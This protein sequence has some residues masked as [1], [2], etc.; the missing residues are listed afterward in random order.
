MQFAVG[1]SDG[2]TTRQFFRWYSYGITRF[3]VSS[4][5]GAARPPAAPPVSPASRE[6][7][8]P[9]GLT[10]GTTMT[11]VFFRSFLIFFLPSL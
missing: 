1:G 6:V 2:G 10:T 5:A 8:K 3:A 7:L 4:P 11:R 9:S